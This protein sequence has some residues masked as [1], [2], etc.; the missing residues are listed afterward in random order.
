ML[1]LVS[2][3]GDLGVIIKVLRFWSKKATARADRPWLTGVVAALLLFLGTSS[4]FS[5]SLRV[6]EEHGSRY[7]KGDAG[8]SLDETST[9]YGG[10]LL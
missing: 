1:V 3:Y 7:G 4:F 5:S 9:T 2:G 8:A 6:R 10:C